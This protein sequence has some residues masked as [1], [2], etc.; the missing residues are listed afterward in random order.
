MRTKIFIGILLLITQILSLIPNEPEIISF[1]GSFSQNYENVEEKY[2]QIK[3]TSENIPKYLKIKV[4]NI[5]EGKNPNYIM[6]FVKSLDESAE[7]EQISS[8]EKLSLMWLTKDQL[9]R[10]KNLLYVT[11]YTYP[12]NYNLNLESSDIINL[13]FNSQ[14][15]LYVTELNKNVEISFSPEEGSSDSTYVS[16]WGIGNKNPKVEVQTTDDYQHYSKNNIFKINSYNSTL[17]LKIQG[18]E[19]DVINIGSSTFDANSINSL[20]NNSPEKKGFI[21]RDYANQE[22][23]YTINIDGYKQNEDY[24]ISGLIYSKIAEIYYK[25]QNKEIIDETINVINNGSFIH[26]I[27]PSKE[28]KKYICIR[29]PTKN[30]DKYS[31]DEIFYSMQL[32]DPKQS[33]S[34]IGLFSPQNIGEIYPRML[35]EEEIF[36]YTGIPIPEH[37]KEISFSMISKFGLPDMYFDVCTNYPL[38]NNYNYYNLYTLTDPISLNGQSSYSINLENSTIYS[39]MNRN[40]YVLIVK[41]TKSQIKNGLPC[42]FNTVFSSNDNNINL[43]E[44]ELFSRFV[45]KGETN[46]YKIDFTGH[47]DVKRIFVDLILFTGDLIFN[48]I[49]TNIKAKKLYMANKI[50]YIIDI[51][52]K[53]TS[54]EINFKIIGSKNS[55]YSIKYNLLLDKDDSWITNTIESGLSYLVTIDPEGKDSS[56]EIKPYKYVKFSNLKIYENVP[57]LV[58]FNSLNCKL[59]VTAKRFN[60]DGSYYYEPIDSFDQYYQDIVFKNKE[61]VYEY[62]LTIKEMDSSVY[63]NKLCMVYASSIDLNKE[64]DFDE[65]QIVISDNEPKQIVFK[66][67]VQEIEYIYPHNNIKNDVIVQFNLL[68]IAQYSVEISYGFKNKNTTIQTGNDIIYIHHNEWKKIMT[69]D[70]I[71]PLVIKIKK[72]RSYES[73]E[74]KLII[75]VKAV[76]DNTPSYIKKNQA[77]IDFLLGN[78]TQYYYTDL[79]K[80]EEGYAMVNYYRGSGRLFGKI[81]QKNTDKKEEGANWREKY[82]F[83]ETVAESMEF[84]GYIKKIMIRKNETN[85]CEDGCYL[86]LTLRS[87]IESD[88]YFDFR[89]HP[90]NIMIHTSTPDSHKDTI[91]IISIPLNE[92]IIGNININ[93]NNKITEYYST[94]FSHDA[95]NI[96]VD[97]QSKV[98][99]FNIKVGSN[100]KPTLT[101]KDFNF[102]S[103]GDDTIFVINKTVFLEKCKKRGIDIPYNNSLFGLGMTIGIWTD[104]IDSLYTTV[105]SIKVNLPFHE[106]E[107]Y[108]K[109]NIYEVKSD[110]KT[111]CKP[112][113]LENENLYRCLFIIFYYGI[114]SA[115]HLLIYPE[116]QEY[117]P[118]KMYADFIIND[119]YEYYDYSYLRSK[120]P[121]KASTYSTEKTGEDYL[122]IPHS[123]RRDQHVFVSIIS[124]SDSIIELFTSFYTNDTQL[125]PN[126]SSPQ[127]F[128]IQKKFEFEFPTEEDLL[129]TIKA[130]R[131]EGK[132]KWHSDSAEYYLSGK[133][134]IISLSSSLIDRT[135]PQ[136]L[137][138]NLEVT[139]IN[140]TVKEEGFAFHISHMLRPKEINFDQIP[141]GKS[142]RMAY[143]D[144]D[145]PVYVYT[146]LFYLDK[147]LHSFINIYELIGKMDKSLNNISPFELNAALVNDSVIMDAKLNKAILDKIEFN[148]KGVYDPM[149]RTGFVLI[150]KDDIKKSGLEIKDGPSVILK[151]AKNLNYPNM[152]DT[153]FT[154][155]TIETSIIQENTEIPIVPGIYQFGKLSLSSNKNVYRLKSSNA[156][157]YM[158]I[159]FSSISDKIKYVIGITPEDTETHSFKDYKKDDKNGKEVITFDSNPNKYSYLFLIIYHTDKASTDKLTNYV[160]KYETASNIA[161]FKE[162]ELGKEQ[163]FELEKKE[164]GDYYVYNFKIIPLPY[165]NVDITYFIRFISKSDYLENEKDKSIALKETNSFVAEIADYEKKDDKLLKGYKTKEIN[166]RY[167]QVI[168]MVNDN[169]N[170]AIVSYGSIFITE[171]N[172][173]K[174]LLI[175]LACLIVI[176][177]VIYVVRLYIKKKRDINRNMQGLD[178]PMVSRYTQASID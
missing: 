40:Q 117:T 112:T 58:N 178:G 9:D 149:L 103:F 176:G 148:Y 172:W 134:K 76:Q 122:Y 158:R 147:D 63:N 116:I 156:E 83:P 7:R 169:G 140:K 155:V 166:Y 91:P 65:R 79:G 60:P 101:D 14:F 123:R 5:I 80:G 57:F 68:D 95:E 141:L 64:K 15:N 78:N 28:N 38:C 17:T 165:E 173:W 35:K 126:P 124:E 99:N 92:Y 85:K 34:K 87:S 41:C 144:T 24:Y 66:N 121:N 89:E 115:K 145:L 39:T 77:Q 93:E 53:F 170:Y 90:F 13:N 97:F 104:K 132:I 32:T 164:D 167:V 26:I 107:Q 69:T 45:K 111:L 108:E 49:E 106:N 136:K 67:D 168:A 133:D 21:F 4:N 72:D 130:I 33:D 174:I 70:D 113:K 8:G 12:C 146:E 71:C 82:K 105:Y 128:M 139:F 161:D 102:E 54:K 131:G 84:Y 31:F 163:G 142:T 135:D 109:L 114:D 171:S 50:F 138:S 25:N 2:F 81:V 18:E 150:T 16:I 120:I 137:F 43:K 6:T 177:V 73:K 3:I 129:V 30:A 175:V 152:K 62:M 23:C 162:Y 55:Y 96:L 74:P 19:N 98:V 22:E 59:N 61:N 51:D 20:I 154:R 153:K 86:L 125:S 119:R 27:N 52:D 37:T 44:D 100:N 1:N 36:I 56:G 42:G 11:C 159:E 151:I 29:F 94:Y 75:S 157:K 110:Q 46:L 143:R 10:E 48:P 127:L 88:R 118:F 160:F 47:K